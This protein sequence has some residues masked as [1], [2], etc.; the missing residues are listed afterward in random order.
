MLTDGKNYLWAF[1]QLSGQT[2]FTRWGTNE[3]KGIIA[4]L[5]KR[6][7]V[8]SI[9]EHARG[10]DAAG[11]AVDKTFDHDSA[12]Y[13]QRAFLREKL[14]RAEELSLLAELQS[15]YTIHEGGGLVRLTADDWVGRW[16]CLRQERPDL[17]PWKASD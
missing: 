13:Y 2:A 15:L 8:R 4:A 10:Y 14:P 3:V 1:C 12:V 9:N 7:A 5:E 16:R 6:F 17:H 11:R